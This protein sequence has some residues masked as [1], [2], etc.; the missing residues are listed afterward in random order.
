MHKMEKY[1]DKNYLRYFLLYCGIFN[2]TV[3]FLVGSATKKN[4]IFIYK[5]FNTQL[6]QISV[7]VSYLYI[8]ELNLLLTPAKKANKWSVLVKKHKPPLTLS[9]SYCIS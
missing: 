5:I 2:T 4:P 7:C 3:V 1:L 9:M 8:I 6:G